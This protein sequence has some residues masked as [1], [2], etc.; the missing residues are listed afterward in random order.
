MA[1]DPVRRKQKPFDSTNPGVS[2]GPNSANQ[3]PFGLFEDSNSTN[4]FRTEC[5]SD[6]SSLFSNSD[7]GSSSM[8]TESMTSVDSTRNS[9]SNED[10][11]SDYLFGDS[12]RANSGFSAGPNLQFEDLGLNSV[13]NLAS[14]FLYADSSGDS[15]V[16][17]TGFAGYSSRRDTNWGVGPTN[18]EGTVMLRRPPRDKLTQTFYS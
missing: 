9:T 8:S 14:P 15:V 2:S 10:F 1:I 3:P 5:S 18:G 4:P 7:E 12:D 17:G 13:P 16:V 11:Y 6:S